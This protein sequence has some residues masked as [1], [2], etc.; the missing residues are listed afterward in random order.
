MRVAIAS[1]KGGTGKTT[2]SVNLALSLDDVQLVDCDVEEPNC[3]P[4]L[5]VRTG[6]VE[7]I[8]VFVPEID[9]QRCDLCGECS[10]FCRFHALAA[11]G[12]RVLVFPELCHWC[13]G[14][15][16]VCPRDAI[17]PRARPLG[18]IESGAGGG[19]RFMRGILNVGEAMA[20]PLIRALKDRIDGTGDVILDSPPGTSCPVI[21]TVEGAD[22]CVL[23]TE[24]TPFGL[25]DLKLAVGVVRSMGVPFGVIINRDGVGDGRVE[26]YCA[27]EGIPLL[28]KI[29]QDRDIAG[30]YSQG[31]PFVTSMPEWADRFR[32]LWR[33]MEGMAGAKADAAPA[34]GVGP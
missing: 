18:V 7:D 11:V 24:P 17:T 5:P 21:E 3:L 1:G 29:P 20:T 16:M 33:E 22:V 25:H 9:A 26:E 30:L 13:G 14:C 4:F 15:E 34:G 23:V 27:G 8:N 6:G 19:I 12:E 32:T 28:L 10:K 2:V 31:K